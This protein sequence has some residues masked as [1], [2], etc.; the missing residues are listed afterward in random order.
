MPEGRLDN[1]Q[2]H[3]LRVYGTYAQSLGRFGSVDLTPLWRVNSGGVYSHT[4]STRDAGAAA[5]E[6]PGLRRQRRQRGDAPD[7]VL[8]RARRVRLQGLR[9]DGL[10]G[11]LQPRGVA[12]AAP[13]VQGRSVQHVRTTRSRSRGIAR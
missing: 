2:R 4:A 5:G 6:Q 8:R 1:F 10:R 3:K 7:G 11:D 12:H 13:L 9:R